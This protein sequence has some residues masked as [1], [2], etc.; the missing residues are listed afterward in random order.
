MNL[1]I[2][3]GLLAFALVAILAAILL[4]VSEQRAE[5]ARAYNE[6]VPLAVST[7]AIETPPATSNQG[8]ESAPIR[9]AF[10][11]T[12]EKAVRS[13]TDEMK[14]AALNG[15]IH[16]FASELRSLH[17]Q[18]WELE[19][20]LRGLTEMVDHIEE[21]RANHVSIEEEAR[22]HAQTGNV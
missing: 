4:G 17:Q 10:P 19:Q 8:G 14:L 2:I 3:G 1:L 5:K 6:L 21:A 22:A 12:I 15:Q 11:V 20:R 18:A 16:E 7:Q 9:Q 13:S